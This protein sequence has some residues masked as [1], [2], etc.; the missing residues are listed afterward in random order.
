[1]YSCKV[2]HDEFDEPEVIEHRERIDYGAGRGQWVT[3]S[4]EH[5]CPNC[6]SSNITENE[7]ESETDSTPPL[8]SE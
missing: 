1:M 3:E 7:S 6:G 2:C 5:C 4:Y 8:S